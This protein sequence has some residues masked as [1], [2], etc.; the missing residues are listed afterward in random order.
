[1]TLIHTPE[2]MAQMTCAGVSFCAKYGANREQ[3]FLPTK[4]EEEASCTGCGLECVPGQARAC[5][6]AGMPG[7]SSNSRLRDD[8]TEAQ[9]IKF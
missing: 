1:M 6:A 9:Q 5:Q 4:T 7:L 2:L 3:V 8:E